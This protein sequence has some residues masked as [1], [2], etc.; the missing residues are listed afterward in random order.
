MLFTCHV[1]TSCEPCR[2]VGGYFSSFFRIHLFIFSIVLLLIYFPLLFFFK[3]L[4]YLFIYLFI[5]FHLFYCLGVGGLATAEH[6]QVGVG[7]QECKSWT[8]V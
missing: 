7:A 1:R 2:G 5:L 3:I 4:F 6:R 8:S